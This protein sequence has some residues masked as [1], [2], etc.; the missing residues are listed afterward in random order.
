MKNIKS[1]VCKK[2]NALIKSGISRSEAFKKAWAEVLVLASNLKK[3]DVIRTEFYS[4]LWKRNVSTSGVVKNV[5]VSATGVYFT[6]EVM[7]GFN[8]T[9]VM[10]YAVVSKKFE[11]VA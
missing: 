2:A 1:N 11:R 4:S 8:P 6:V 9:C 7:D 3:G 10:R 5:S